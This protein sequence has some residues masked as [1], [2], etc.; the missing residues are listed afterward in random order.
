MR[1][2]GES[3]VYGEASEEGASSALVRKLNNG[4]KDYAST[5]CTHVHAHA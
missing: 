2:E 4:I 3:G 1:N 5:P